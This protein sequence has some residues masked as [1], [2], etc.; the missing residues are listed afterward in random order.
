MMIKRGLRDSAAFKET[1]TER[2]FLMRDL[3][4]VE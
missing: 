1:L 4:A 3:A 2:I